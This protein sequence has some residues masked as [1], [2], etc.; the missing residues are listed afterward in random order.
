MDG[1]DLRLHSVRFPRCKPDRSFKIVS[2]ACNTMIFRELGLPYQYCAPV[3]ISILVFILFTLKGF[4][5]HPMSE[6]LNP[7]L[8]YPLQ[9]IY[10]RR[11]LSQSLL[12]QS[13]PLDFLYA[14]FYNSASILPGQALKHCTKLPAFAREKACPL[15]STP[16]ASRTSSS[17]YPTCMSCASSPPSFAALGCLPQA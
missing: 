17:K 6:A 1:W 10:L 7:I 8:M 2:D 14:I 12:L 11:L 15:S 13:N 16:I 5:H 4:V 9:L 3:I